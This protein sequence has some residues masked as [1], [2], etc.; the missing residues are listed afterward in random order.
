MMHQ[1]RLCFAVIFSG[2]FLVGHSNRLPPSEDYDYYHNDGDVYLEHSDS[3]P[4]DG[5]PYRALPL[6]PAE[7]Y[8]MSQRQKLKNNAKHQG[9]RTF[10]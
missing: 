5:G 10:L 9:Q 6:D 3:P 4:T 8:A 1:G 7:Y 2:L